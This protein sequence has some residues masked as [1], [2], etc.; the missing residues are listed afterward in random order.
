MQLKLAKGV[1]DR[2]VKEKEKNGQQKRQHFKVHVHNMALV[3]PV[4]RSGLVVV[5]NASVYAVGTRADYVID[6]HDWLILV[7]CCV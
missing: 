7:S 2:S 5:E 6:L 4:N 3:Y 1:T